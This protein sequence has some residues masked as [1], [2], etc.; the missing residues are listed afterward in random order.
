MPTEVLNSPET[1]NPVEVTQEARVATVR[2]EETPQ[3][4]FCTV[5]TDKKVTDWANLNN[6]WHKNGLIFD[7][8]VEKGYLDADG[9][10]LKKFETSPLF[11]SK[12]VNGEFETTF[13]YM[14]SY[15]NVG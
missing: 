14:L 2:I 13:K 10:P 12:E 15:P 4:I 3:G 11:E 6:L 7:A 5:V 8:L 9:N 1:E